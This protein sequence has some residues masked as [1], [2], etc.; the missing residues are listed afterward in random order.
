M[1]LSDKLKQH[2]NLIEDQLRG[3]LYKIHEGPAGGLVFMQHDDGTYVECWTQDEPEGM[4]WDQAR[5]HVKKLNHGGYND[6]SLPN[7][8]ELDKMFDNRD[9]IDNFQAIWYWS[10]TEYSE[11]NAWRQ[12]FNTGIQSNS[13]KHYHYRV[14][15]IRRFK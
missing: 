12:L 9:R 13:S 10:D 8:N 2:Q 7:K 4:K 15:A 5:E 1:K 3:D 14:R 11:L 6:W